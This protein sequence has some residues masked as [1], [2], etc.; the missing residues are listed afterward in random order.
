MN[1]VKDVCDRARSLWLRVVR[2]THSVDDVENN[3]FYRLI[4][5][6]NKVVAGTNFEASR[7]DIK[8]RLSRWESYTPPNVN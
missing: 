1:R 5:G 8:T 2:S 6:K 3:E 7:F 4:D